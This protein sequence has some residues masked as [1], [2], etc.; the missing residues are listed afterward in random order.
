MK[1]R[2]QKGLLRPEKSRKRD[3]HTRL[4]ERFFRTW[5][6]SA[7]RRLQIPLRIVG[8]SGSTLDIRFVGI[9]PQLEIYLHAGELGV[10]VMHRQQ[11]WDLIEVNEASPQRRGHSYFC[12]L[13]CPEARI[14]YPTL[15]LLWRQHTFEPFLAWVNETLLAARW[16]CLL[17]TPGMTAA[18][19]LRDEA[20]VSK[21]IWSNPDALYR[22]ASPDGSIRM[23]PEDGTLIELV[24]LRVPTDQ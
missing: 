14:L 3:Q 7:R 5:L 23:S 13:C 19:L 17:G 16:L 4:V 22:E 12:R 10:A 1:R 21:R 24:P 20:E 6:A 11:C 2:K 18:S 8:R 9:T 15:G